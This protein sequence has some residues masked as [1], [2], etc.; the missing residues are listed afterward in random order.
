MPTMKQTYNESTNI[1][2][3][4]LFVARVCLRH[5]I[6]FA[7]NPPETDRGDIY[8]IVVFYNEENCDIVMDMD[9]KLRSGEYPGHDLYFDDVDEALELYK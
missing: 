4:A 7:I 8:N 2:A 3:E 9:E 1:D 6:P 5:H